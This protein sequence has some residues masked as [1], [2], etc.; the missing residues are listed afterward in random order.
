M[1]TVLVE[2][3]RFIVDASGQRVAVVLDLASNE[4]LFRF[5]GS[6]FLRWILVCRSTKSIR[7]AG[8]DRQKPFCGID[9]NL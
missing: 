7:L 6:R 8:F 3:E 9:A 1:R 2:K 5:S 4:Q